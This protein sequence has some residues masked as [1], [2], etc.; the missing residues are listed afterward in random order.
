MG[1]DDP[2]ITYGFGRHRGLLVD[3]SGIEEI[4][5]GRVLL[6]LE[7]PDAD[8][9]RTLAPRLSGVIVEEP[10]TPYAPEARALWSLP[11]PVL[12]GITVDDSWLGHEVVV[13]FDAATTAPFL[14][15]AAGLRLHAEVASL[16]EALEAG[17]LADGWA[18]LRAE[19]LRA[20]PDRERADL[21]KFL[22]ESGRPLPPIRYFDE[23]AGG[24]PAAS[25]G[26]RGVRS[27]LPDALDAFRTLVEQSPEDD[28]L[29]IV[30][31]VAAREEITAF[32]AAFGSRWRLGLDVATP[33]AALGIADLVDDCHLLHVNAADLTQHTMVWDRTV[34]NDVLLPPG[35]LPLV[36]LQL[37]E[38][39]VSVA[40]TQGIPC[41]V[42]L[43][44]RPS[45]QL[46]DQLQAAGVR[47]VS[48]PAP[49]I[50]HWRHLLD[51]TH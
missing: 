25:F 35:H 24:P 23:P 12:T 3:R 21:W 20:L 14:L 30:P 46:H 16:A 44:L 18:P 33:A 13:D 6:Y 8:L 45:P 17:H 10:V 43:D 4:V 48:C 36:I 34:R 15:N 26:R 39:S 38:W 11:V 51:R 2:G 22:A 5:Y 19:D 28:P 37:V 32:R 29:I 49:L 1:E 31:M 7:K 27:L 50:R 41:Q 42:A 47:D 9:I 40:T